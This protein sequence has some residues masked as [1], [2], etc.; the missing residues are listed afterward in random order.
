M[1]MASDASGSSVRKQ[2]NQTGHTRVSGWVTGPIPPAGE[3]S[4]PPRIQEDTLR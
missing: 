1:V 3:S 2:R 4:H